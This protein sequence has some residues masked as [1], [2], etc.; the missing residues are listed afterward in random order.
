VIDGLTTTLRRGLVVAAA[1]TALAGAAGAQAAVGRFPP[2][3]KVD[4]AVVWAVGDGAYPGPTSLGVARL[5]ERGAP[6]RFIYLGD[7]YDSGTASDYA[8]GYAP[9]FGP[10]RAISLPT[11]GNHEWGNR[12]VG[13]N[14]YWSQ[15]TGGTVPPYYAVSLA[16][17]RLV[18]ANS[19]TDH[20]PGSAQVRWLRGQMAGPGTC[21]IVFWHRPRFS[22]GLHGDEADLAPLWNATLGH[23]A[24]V[25]NGHD[26]DMQRMRPVRGV[27]E[28]VSGAGGHYR[29]PVNPTHPRLA[30]SG[31]R[32]FGALRLDLRPG[33]ARYAFVSTAGRVLDS[34][35]VRCSV[36]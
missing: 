24:L 35:T 31:D 12:A 1:T 29:Y 5:V 13:Y 7:V 17:W 11:P 16:G 30:W 22:A 6:T 10:M 9:I 3:P 18:S 33:S 32:E 27:T 4:R 36:G 19:E 2:P 8:R 14:P 28:L 34:G 25:L 23:A 21:K 15:V 26:H 20:G